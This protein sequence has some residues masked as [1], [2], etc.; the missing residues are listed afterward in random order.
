MRPGSVGKKYPPQPLGPIPTASEDTTRERAHTTVR[1][2]GELLQ[3]DLLRDRC[4]GAVAL[5]WRRQDRRVRRVN[6]HRPA[7][8]AL[9]L[10]W[11]RPPLPLVGKP[12]CSLVISG[13][14]S[15]ADVAPPV[16]TRLGC[17]HAHTHPHSHTHIQPHTPTY[18]HIF[19][20]TCEHPHALTHIHAHM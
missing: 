12:I 9:R 18:T 11:Q 16:A 1:P 10:A 15:S 17:T 2:V 8:R 19:A 20:H 7:P 3:E 14:K 6:A 4:R 5:G 13:K